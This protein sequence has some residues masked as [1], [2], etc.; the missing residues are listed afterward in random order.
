MKMKKVIPL[1]LAGVFMLGSVNAVLA[2]EKEVGEVIHADIGFVGGDFENAELS[3]GTYYAPDMQAYTTYGSS[4]TIAG[5]GTTTTGRSRLPIVVENGNKVFKLQP[6]D[7]AS[8]I[9]DKSLNNAFGFKLVTLS[10]FG[11]IKDITGDVTVKFRMKVA[12]PECLEK[13]LFAV[14]PSH[15]DCG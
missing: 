8:A 2:E 4:H 1:M 14:R 10:D 9:S 12:D 3:G 15:S 6:K 5:L 7:L 11:K 13:V